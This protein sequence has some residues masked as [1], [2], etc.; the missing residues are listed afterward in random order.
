MLPFIAP[1]RKDGVAGL[2]VVVHYLF[3]FQVDHKQTQANIKHKGH[4]S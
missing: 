3:R 2:C 4:P 1:S